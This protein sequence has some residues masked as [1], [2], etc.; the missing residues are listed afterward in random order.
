MP[1]DTPTAIH[2]DLGDG[3]HIVGIGNIRVILFK[4]EP[5]WYAQGLEIDYLSQGDTM[6][7]AKD[8]FEK[9]LTYTIHE[10]LKLHGTVDPVLKVAPQEMWSQIL[11]PSVLSHK[12]TQVSFHLNIEEPR[13]VLLPF[14][15]IQ[16]LQLSETI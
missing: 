15:A 4:E 16:Y 12:Y 6:E 9:G 2:G 1:E 7:A 3:D 5:Y 14:Q 11:Q 8:S 10:N 13:P